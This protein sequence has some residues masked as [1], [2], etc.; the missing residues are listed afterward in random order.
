[1]IKKNL[2][3]VGVLA[4][5]LT[6]IGV[7]VAYLFKKNRYLRDDVNYQIVERIHERLAN[8]LKQL[9]QEYTRDTTRRN[10]YRAIRHTD[11]WDYF[12]DSDGMARKLMISIEL[13]NSCIISDPEGKLAYIECRD[14][15]NE[16]L[17][18]IDE[19]SP[20]L[21][22]SDYLFDKIYDSMRGR[23]D[24]SIESIMH[25]FEERLNPDWYELDDE[26]TEIVLRPIYPWD[27]D[28]LPEECAHHVVDEF[29]SNDNPSEED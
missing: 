17:K 10:I 16:C 5:L 2:V 7:S 9:F 28:W 18:L 4:S 26:S 19:S 25:E 20:K 14:I 27:S 24:K 3:K 11:G 23:E 6:C 22:T 15:L 12:C 21:D 29:V 1:M 8:S 13:L